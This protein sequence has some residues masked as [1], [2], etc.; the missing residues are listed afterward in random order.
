MVHVG[1]SR[2]WGEGSKEYPPRR[3]GRL[4]GA[5]GHCGDSGS[6]GREWRQARV[7][8]GVATV[9][10]GIQTEGHERVVGIDVVQPSRAVL[11]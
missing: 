7:E 4:T 1:W 2:G 8:R 10:E 5:G 9:D 11:V 6:R 3:R